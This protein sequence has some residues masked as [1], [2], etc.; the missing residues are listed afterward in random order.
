[1]HPIYRI[2]PEDFHK[3]T[4]CPNIRVD[5][6]HTV[7]QNVGVHFTEQNAV[8]RTP[9]YQVNIILHTMSIGTMGAH[10][11]DFFYEK[12]GFKP[13]HNHCVVSEV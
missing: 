10:S 6:A 1:M 2:Q 12:S 9:N 3:Q 11:S 4:V 13:R 5:F 7:C 8:F